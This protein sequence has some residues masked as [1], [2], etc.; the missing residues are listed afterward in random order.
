M[1]SHKKDFVF[2]LGRGRS[3]TTLFRS[4]LNSHSEISIA[5]EAIFIMNLYSKYGHVKDWDEDRVLKFSADLWLEDRLA[6]WGL[7]RE[8]VTEDLLAVLQEGANS[9]ADFCR[10][11][12]VS[13]ARQDG[14]P[15]AR[16]VGDKNPH[17]SLMVDKLERLYPGSKFIHMVRD[18][19]D[20]IRSYKNVKFDT[21]GTASLAQRWKL[22]NE[23]ILEVYDQHPEKFHL[24]KF[25]DLLGC[26]HETLAGVCEFL[27]VSFEEGML[28]FYKHSNSKY[29]WHRNL[30][31]KLQTDKI[32]EWRSEM[33][34]D[35]ICVADKICQPLGAR[36]D[37]PPDEKSKRRA[38]VLR[39]VPGITYGTVLTQM[40]RS[41][42]SFPLDFRHQV[43]KCYR[44]LTGS[45]EG[46]QH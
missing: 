41:L 12:Y 21:R 29:S 43:I 5:P 24:F 31:R 27:G 3:G 17:Y 36:F 26:P 18:Y 40:E 1:I 2:V 46:P 32:E 8:K 9:F 45:Y 7:D 13:F 30:S 28:E 10:E 34:D 11:V 15:D 44:R 6:F 20:N 38:S 42:F 14:K 39:L 33:S 19:R 23:H 25:E 4:I 35:D 37:Y 22:Y 16:I